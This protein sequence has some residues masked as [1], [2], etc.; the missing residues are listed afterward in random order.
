MTEF[1]RLEDMEYSVPGKK[2]LSIPHL[3]IEKGIRMELWD[4][5]EQGK[6]HY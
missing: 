4:Q 2:I 1:I 3:S 5:T 6:A